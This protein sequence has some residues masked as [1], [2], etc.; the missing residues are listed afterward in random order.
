M[1]YIVFLFLASTPGIVRA[2]VPNLEGVPAHI[3]DK[4]LNFHK[5]LNAP[6]NFTVAVTPAPPPRYGLAGL[7]EADEDDLNRRDDSGDI[8]QPQ[9][10]QDLFRFSDRLS[11]PE[12]AEE[13]LYSR[14]HR[15]KN[16]RKERLER[17]WNQFLKWRQKQKRKRRIKRRIL[18]AMRR[19]IE[20]KF[21]ELSNM[22]W[23]GIRRNPAFKEK[24]KIIR[25]KINQR[26]KAVKRRKPNRKSSGRM[27]KR[28]SRKEKRKKLRQN[29]RR[30]RKNRRK[31]NN[32]Q[33]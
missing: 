20:N 15:S 28:K 21:G 30:I 5:V 4:I 19:K 29:R 32:D 33:K 10:Q 26:L 22:R 8:P 16:R 17:E 27:G 25:K 9:L 13:D 12:K 7:A 6:D 23:A 11:T 3:R 14:I 2:A 31:K 1:K 18:K 24:R